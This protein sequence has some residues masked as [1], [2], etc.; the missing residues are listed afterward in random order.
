MDE[1]TSALVETEAQED[2]IAEPHHPVSSDASESAHNQGEHTETREDKTAETDDTV[3]S[4]QLDH[5]NGKTDDIDTALLQS[6]EPKSKVI[7]VMWHYNCM[8]C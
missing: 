8:L 2:K 7:I 4:N 6:E 1:D 5:N 3:D